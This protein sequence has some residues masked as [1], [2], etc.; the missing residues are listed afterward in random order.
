[1]AK[2]DRELFHQ[3]L[4]KHTDRSGF[5]KLTQKE[6]MDK[7][8]VSQRTMSRLYDE[9]IASKKLVKYS[10]RRFKVVDPSVTVWGQD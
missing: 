5:L 9:L 1:M 8:Q 3:Y 10:D 6:L 4:W 2:I 7:L